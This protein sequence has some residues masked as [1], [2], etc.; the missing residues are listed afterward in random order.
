MGKTLVLG[1]T[2]TISGMTADILHQLSPSTLRVATS[3]ERKLDRLRTRFP[4]AELVL[5]DW[6]DLDSLVAAMD[7][8]SKLMVVTP[9]FRTDEHVVTPNIIEAAKQVG[10]IELIARII[11]IPPGYD[12]TK[13]PQAYIDTRCG[14]A[15]HAIA[16]PRLDASGLPVAY[17]NIPAWIMH[18]VTEFFAPSV[19][20]SRQIAMP[21]NSDAK[22]MWVSD[23]DISE[24]FARILT[25]PV[26]Q[27]V[28]KEYVLTSMERHSYG[29]V[30]REISQA[31]GE[32]VVYVDDAEPLRKIMGG[33]FD[34]LMTYFDGDGERYADVVPTDT[35]AQLLGRPAETIS[36]YVVRHLELFR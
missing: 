25:D 9:D 7:G 31:L 35:I 14:A 30:A 6:Y 8:A 21:G 23:L 17:V 18:M 13:E 16:K 28:G 34:T 15:Q 4:D 22:R 27:H 26:E 32:E 3:R 36:D 11:A 5:A 33:G 29:D 19:K 20:E 12:I 24:I 1:A 2:G 10:S